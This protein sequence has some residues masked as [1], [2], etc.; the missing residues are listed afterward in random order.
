LAT[1]NIARLHWSED[2]LEALGRRND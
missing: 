2:S 1:I